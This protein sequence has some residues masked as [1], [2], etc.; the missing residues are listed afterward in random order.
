M[1]QTGSTSME[2]YRATWTGISGDRFYKN[3]PM[4]NF[5]LVDNPWLRENIIENHGPLGGQYLE[6]TYIMEKDTH[7]F[8]GL[9]NNGLAWYKSPAYGGWGGRCQLYQ[10]YAEVHK[11]WTSSV[12]TQDEI[13]LKD[14]RLEAS[15]QATIWRWREAYQH[16]FAARMDWNVAEDLSRANHNPVIVLNG[17]EGK[18]LATAK[19]AEGERIT[20]SPKGSHDP[21]NDELSFNWFVYKEAGNF[22]GDFDL[23][24][25]FEEEIGFSMPKLNSGQALDIILEAKDNGTPSLSSYRRIVLRHP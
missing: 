6:A 3:G 2:Y 1:K 8:L 20:H 5:E 22:S 18:S 19:A 24:N 4:E 23:E 25:S 10:S 15:N 21:D 14:G 9:I 7:S 11:I 16:D 12:R 17:N 13:R